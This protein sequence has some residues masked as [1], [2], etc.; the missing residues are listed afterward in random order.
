MKTYHST[1][2]KEDINKA[3]NRK[4]F[5]EYKDYCFSEGAVMFGV[6]RG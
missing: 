4:N 3:K 2:F 5:Q 1:K 6:C